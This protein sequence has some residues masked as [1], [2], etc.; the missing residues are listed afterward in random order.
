MKNTNDISYVLRL[1]PDSDL[2]LSIENFV[3]EH[4][5]AAGWIATCVG[6]LSAWSIRFANQKNSAAAVG[7]FEIISP[8][9]TLSLNCCHLHISIADRAGNVIGGH[10][11]HGCKIYTT[12]EIILVQSARYVST[13]EQDDSTGWK[14]LIVRKK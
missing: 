1:L 9:G 8:T 10:L 6:S 2:R 4:K 7:H 5:I 13:R 12:A 14:E 11:V 3:K